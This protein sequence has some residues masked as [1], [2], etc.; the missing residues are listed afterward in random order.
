M[1]RTTN[2]LRQLN[3]AVARTHLRRQQQ[4]VTKKHQLSSKSNKTT[5]E[6]N[7]P[8]YSD[9]KFDPHEVA[10]SMIRTAATEIRTPGTEAL[11]KLTTEQKMKN[12]VMALSLIGFSTGVWYYSIQSVGKPEGGME[13]L[14]ADAEDAKQIHISN[15]ENE[16][17]VEEL[18]QLDITMS[19]FEGDDI[20][21]AVAA[22]DDIAQREEDINNMAGK[23]GKSGRPLWK[24]VVF[25]W[26][27]E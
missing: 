8:S 1:M 2:T 17:S 24:K 20:I 15:S 23:K 6:K 18:T 16:K 11:N 19:D 5:N 22:D 25:F 10:D 21:V 12:Y 3:G 14:L 27:K 7:P 26:K 4:Q 13:E 9:A